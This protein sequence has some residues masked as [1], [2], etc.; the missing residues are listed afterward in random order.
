MKKNWFSQQRV[1]GVAGLALALA[2][3]FEGCKS[4]TTPSLY[5][6]SAPNKPAP[7]IDT[8]IS[9]TPNA[10]A[11]VT[12]LTLKGQNFSTKNDENRVFFGS[13]L[14]NVFT[15]SA[16]QL[17]MRAPILPKDTLV[18]VKVNV[19]SA[20]LFSNAK[21][22]KLTLAVRDFDSLKFG[23]EPWSTAVDAAGNFYV[24]IVAGGVGAG[25][26]K[27]ALDGRRS[28]FAP[29]KF[30]TK[31]TSLRFSPTG[32][33][34]GAWNIQ[35][36]V[37]FP[38]GNADPALWVTLSSGQI[39]DFDF[40][41]QGNI[42]AAGYNTSIYRITSSKSI[43][44]F[45]LDANIRSVRINNGYVYLAGK[46]FPDSL[47]KI[48]RYKIISSDS[49]GSQ[50]VI[51]NFSAS[52]FNAGSNS[53][54]SIAFTSQGD[55]FVGTDRSESILI[56]HPDGTAEEFYTGL[57]PPTM[58]V[59]AWG[60]GTELLGVRGTASGGGVSASSKIVRINTQV[61]GAP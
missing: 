36:L 12:M 56:V 33:L 50:E 53:M 3:M 16:T 45:P 18:S 7:V 28:D 58:H 1:I 40:D 46:T 59:L 41:A 23:E 34:Y 11:G 54:Y 2:L 43:K 13:T 55:L 32:V 27:F 26:K 24:S 37:Q 15:S 17:T 44:S 49:L 21:L 4:D 25:V 19:V 60:K 52:S 30:E 38:G 48:I 57:L 61:T 9:A 42:W 29:R 20:Q 35:A 10:Y 6:P 47:E 39:Y 14:V 51:Y 8:I 22:F 5:D 31:Y